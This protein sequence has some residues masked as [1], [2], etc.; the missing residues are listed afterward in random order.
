MGLQFS[1]KVYDPEERYL[2]LKTILQKY[3]VEVSDWYKDF[4]GRLVCEEVT[5]LH[6]DILNINYRE[7]YDALTR[8]NLKGIDDKNKVYDYSEKW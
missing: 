8:L 7:M 5:S 3:K 1:R 2:D 4:E 6:S